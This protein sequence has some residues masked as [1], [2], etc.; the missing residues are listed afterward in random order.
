[1]ND[2]TEPLVYVGM[3]ATVGVDV[4]EYPDSN[5]LAAAVGAPPTGKRFLFRKDTQVDYFDGEPNA[6]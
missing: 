6:V 2:G 4:V 3:A 1:V 5:K